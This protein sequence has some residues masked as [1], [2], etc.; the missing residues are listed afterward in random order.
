[1]EK[2]YPWEWATKATFEL[3]TCVDQVTNECIMA[4]ILLSDERKWDRDLIEI[5]FFGGL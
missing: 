5:F 3:V 1:M 4:D 2:E